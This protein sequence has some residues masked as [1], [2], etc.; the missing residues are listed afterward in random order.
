MADYAVSPTFGTLICKAATGL[1]LVNRAELRVL[2]TP[3]K[4]IS[5]RMARR[6]IGRRIDP[7]NFDDALAMAIANGWVRET[8]EV[9]F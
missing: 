7:A 3:L 1:E 9:C 8:K 5:R 2:V 4:S 6:W